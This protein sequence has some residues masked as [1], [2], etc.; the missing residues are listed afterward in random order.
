MRKT[1]AA[2]VVSAHFIP[3]VSP[4][5]SSPSGRM[6]SEQ[7]VG[8]ITTATNSEELRVMI[9]VSGKNAMNSPTIP[10]QKAKGAN[11]ATVVVVAAIT[12]IATSPV[13]SFAASF[14]S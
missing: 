10:G 9:S 1:S 2:E 13:A 6:N 7:R 5:L 11:A 4:G 8:L 12:G 3:R 14:L